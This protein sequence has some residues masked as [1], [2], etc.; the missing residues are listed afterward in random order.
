MGGGLVKAEVPYGSGGQ[1]TEGGDDQDG[2]TGR[3]KWKVMPSA[4][5]ARET[6]EHD[7]TLNKNSTPGHL[8][9]RILLD[10]MVAQQALGNFAKKQ[11]ALD[12]FMCW[13]DIQEY[14]SIPTPDYRRS[15]ALH[16]YHKYIKAGAVLEVG[17]IDSSEKE[18]YKELLEVAR[19]NST[20]LT[21]EVYDHVQSKCF[22]EMFHNIYLPFRD[23][24][25]F[26]ALSRKLKERYNKVHT[27]DFD[28][29]GKL[30]EGGFGLVIHVKKKSTGK[31]YAMKIQT[32]HG[33][34]T[35]FQDD[36]WRADFEK[37]AF[38]CC[39][40]PFIVGLDYAFQT[41]VFACM[42]LGLSTAG[43]LHQQLQLSDSGYLPEERVRF[44]AAEIALALVY[45]HDMGLI[46]RDLK[47]NNVLL[48]A[49]GHIQLVDLGGVVD[50]R[51][52]TLGKADEAQLLVPLLAQSFAQ[53]APSPSKT[54]SPL[55]TLS[56]GMTAY[57]DAAAED[58]VAG[59][60]K[61]KRKLSIMGTFGY[62]APE[63]VI[64]LSQHSHE[65]TGYND[66]V[67]WWSL[68][69]TVFKL[70]TGQ[71]PFT[72]ENFKAFVEICG[73]MT[74]GVADSAP[75]YAIL[76]QEV[77]YPRFLSANAVDFMQRLLD[78]NDNTRLGS[79]P[80]GVKDIKA[81]PFFKGIDWELLEQT[82]VEPP[83][84]PKATFDDMQEAAKFPSF[85]AMMM[86]LG[87]E[88]LLGQTIHETDQ[89]Y[90]SNWYVVNSLRLQL[91][92]VA[93]HFL[94]NIPLSIN[95][96]FVSPYTL[97]KEFG[98]ANEMNQYDA[99]FKARKLLGDR[100][101]SAQSTKML[102]T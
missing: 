17:T 82:H 27:D 38:A 32:K 30:G 96:D 2:T 56:E 42:V 22:L 77:I 67:D 74:R 24:K 11:Q 14:K 59:E 81:H 84:K 50:E 48:N 12:I 95:R 9:L 102:N 98:L 8:E 94:T 97:K 18:M 71:R 49:D 36:P 40:H 87:K 99:N 6:Y 76:F 29:I 90:F 1:V 61:P 43:D 45:L 4:V 25:E 92:I 16:I 41:D 55:P 53:E 5:Q 39:R 79:G 78:V 20:V 21:Q 35:S 62:M 91:A 75:E 57:D 65:M 58:D 47:P 86:D 34:I 52:N 37:Q 26:T 93:L 89:K 88:K 33:L 80:N 73:T 54:H 85:E 72:N 23:Q 51:G 31:H 63:M 69:V 70:L 83:Y 44:Y 13:I 19:V 7:G 100:T 15:K 101:S 3:N 28:Y 46:Y 68:G 10:E 66:S 64:M 60:L